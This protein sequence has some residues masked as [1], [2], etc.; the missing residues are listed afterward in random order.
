[1]RVTYAEAAELVESVDEWEATGAEG[2]AMEVGEV[3]TDRE[4]EAWGQDRDPDQAS[5]TIAP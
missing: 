2:Q 4:Q 1:M 5:D 3:E